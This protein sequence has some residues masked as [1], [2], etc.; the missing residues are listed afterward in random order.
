[1][2][3]RERLH[4]P[5][6]A[7]YQFEDEQADDVYQEEELPTT[8]IIDEGV[9]LN[10]LVGDRNDVAA[11]ECVAPKRKWNPRNKKAT[12]RALDRRRLL[13]RDSDE[14]WCVMHNLILCD[15]LFDFL[16]IHLI[17]WS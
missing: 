4:T 9:A 17:L 7:G 13:D 5:C 11:D 14:F 15:V 2:N 3:P 12:F 6:I 10:S 8:F 16:L 1:V